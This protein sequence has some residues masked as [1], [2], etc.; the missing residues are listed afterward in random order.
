MANHTRWCDKNPKRDIYKN[1]GAKSIA[2]MNEKK[3]QTGITNQ[4]T[5][6]KIENRLI[7]TSVMKGKPGTFLGKKHSEQTKKLQREKALASPHRRLQRNIIEYNGIKLDSSWELALAKR[8]DE[9]NIRWIRPNP[10]PWIDKSGII[11]NYFA[12]FYL[13]D[14]DLYLDPKNPGAIR[15]QKEK[16][17]CLLSQYKNICIIDTIEKCKTYTVS[18]TQQVK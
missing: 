8:L 15:V 4:F 11:H 14:Y 1:S 9:L 7:P 13:L 3:K 6:A 12:D 5:K 18:N 17:E 2:A 10:L 16:I